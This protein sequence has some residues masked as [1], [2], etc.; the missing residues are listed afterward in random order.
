MNTTDIRTQLDALTQAISE[1]EAAK[2]TFLKKV[3][4]RSFRLEGYDPFQLNG[5]DPCKADGSGDR[6]ELVCFREYDDWVVIQCKDVLEYS[7]K[8]GAWYE[9]NWLHILEVA[10]DA[11]VLRIPIKANRSGAGP[12]IIQHNQPLT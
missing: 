6:P 10:K 5:Y 4:G 3:A 11:Q 7:V 12:V 8:H 2:E 9:D 1:A